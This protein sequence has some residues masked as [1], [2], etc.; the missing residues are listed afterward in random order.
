MDE[1]YNDLMYVTTAREVSKLWSI[2]LRTVYSW[3][4]EDRIYAVHVCGSLIISL[5]SVQDLLGNPVSEIK[6]VL[7]DDFLDLGIKEKTQS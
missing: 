7:P 6:V 2:P 3:V 4:D 1:Y 5:R